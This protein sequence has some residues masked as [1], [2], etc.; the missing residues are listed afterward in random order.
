[1][2]QGGAIC[3][4]PGHVLLY[5]VRRTQFLLCRLCARQPVKLTLND[6]GRRLGACGGSAGASSS[7]ILPHVGELAVRG[8]QQCTEAYVALTRRATSCLAHQHTLQSTPDQLSGV[9]YAPK[10]SFHRA[11]ISFNAR[12]SPDLRQ[13]NRQIDTIRCPTT[14]PRLHCT[15]IRHC[16]AH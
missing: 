9:M 2:V 12:N 16:C 3:P 1:M 15:P 14:P 10:N 8:W 11:G 5:P 7:N 13:N 4:C 6:G